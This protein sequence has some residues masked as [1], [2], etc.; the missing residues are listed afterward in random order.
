MEIHQCRRVVQAQR[1]AGRRRTLFPDTGDRQPGSLYRA[2][3]P[4]CGTYPFEYDTPVPGIALTPNNPTLARSPLAIGRFLLVFIAWW[5]I[6]TFLQTMLLLS[7]GLTLGVAAADSV[8]TNA[9]VGL[10]CGFVSNN[11]KDRKSTRL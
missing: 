1:I 8:V 4:P 5:L 2:D 7:F 11:L 9:L 6:W 3:Q 10:A